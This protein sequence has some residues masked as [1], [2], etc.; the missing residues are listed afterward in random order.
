MYTFNKWKRNKCV[1]F[2]ITKFLTYDL[3]NMQMHLLQVLC[4]ISSI[5]YAL[6]NLPFFS[7]LNLKHFF[8]IFFS[9]LNKIIKR[10]HFYIIFI[11]TFSALQK[12]IVHNTHTHIYTH[13]Y[14]HTKENKMNNSWLISTPFSN[15]SVT[16]LVK[17]QKLYNFNS[18]FLQI[19][20]CIS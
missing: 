2:N 18:S 4:N 9:K 16:Q 20:C 10:K 3:Y 1:S 7:N 19:N 11:C 14:T 13:A 8:M 6:T 12:R 15:Y 17:T 5:S